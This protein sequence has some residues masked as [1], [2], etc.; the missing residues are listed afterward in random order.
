MLTV[1]NQ[2]RNFKETPEPKGK[3]DITSNHRFVVQKHHASR[4]HYDFR[5]E[6]DGVLKSWAVPKGP[7][8]S[9]ADKRLAVQVE[10][11]PVSYIGFSGTIP[12]GNYGA[13]KV[14]IWDKGDFTPVNERGE[15]ISE[16]QALT[17]L[18]KGE[19]KFVVKGKKLKGGFVLVQLKKDPRNWL[20]I[21]HK[22]DA[23]VSEKK[24]AN[25]NGKTTRSKKVAAV[26]V[27]TNTADR[28]L[29]QYITPMFATPGKNSFDDKDWLF[30]IKWD[31]FRAVAEWDKKSLK[32]YSRN[33][34]SFAGKY[35]VI[36][37]ALT[38]LKDK[39]VIDGE[40]VALNDEGRPDFQ[41][42]QQ[43][44]DHPESQVIY[45]V[46]DLLFLNGKDVRGLPL[47]ER[48]KLLRK[49]LSKSQ[50]GVVRYCDHVTTKGNAFFKK[51]A[52][53]GLEGMI[54]KKANSKY[55]SGVRTGEWLKIK[56]HNTREAVIAGFTEPRRS[57][58][59]FGALVL[60]EYRDGQFTYIGHTG[61][62]FT[63]DVLK[64]LWQQMRPLITTKSPFTE[65]TKVNS[66]VSWLR[67]RL[68]CQVKFAERTREGLLRQPV[69]LG[70]REDKKAKE[71]KAE[72]EVA[73]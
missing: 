40:I 70:L 6:L 45:Y 14:M 58:K 21:K 33:G 32:F 43:Y 2:K 41:L 67:P 26:A 22:D 36:A 52:S 53:L 23:I 20:L 61:T 54:A 51:T 34:L 29:K 15:L 16:K 71:V 65:K 9:P 47:T 44:G 42:L 72:N 18:K 68:V 13:G 73:K 49:S 62:G 59:H 66:P 4:L 31:G 60:G 57:R 11:H 35:P 27:E 48:K 25:R 38:K 3:K 64:E 63:N 39:L 5:L 10:D 24:P 69:Y 55:Y 28:K 37:K 56:N 19:L 50:K 8:M 7:S 1:Y 30:E 46:F 17:Q 12:E